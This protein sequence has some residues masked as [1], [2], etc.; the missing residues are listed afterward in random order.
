M[1]SNFARTQKFSEFTQH[2]KKDH[3]SGKIRKTRKNQKRKV[4]N[5]LELSIK[6]RTAEEVKVT[7]IAK[8]TREISESAYFFVDIF[9]CSLTKRSL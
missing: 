6:D 8:K 7:K 5:S 9:R 3:Q 4:A 1:L 2:Q